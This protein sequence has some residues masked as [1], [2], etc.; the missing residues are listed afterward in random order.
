MEQTS[1]FELIKNDVLIAFLFGLL[2][3][4][5]LAIAK[6]K[7]FF[8]LPEPLDPGKIPLIFID[9]VIPF[10]LYIG[11]A[12]T[13]PFIIEKILV[14][15]T[16]NGNRSEID[17]SHWINFLTI[18]FISLALL[19]YCVKYRKDIFH[20]IWKH[21]L[22][23]SSYGFDF[24]IGLISW[25]LAF[26]L[27]IF[28]SHFLD[29]II[30]FIFR[31]PQLPQQA[32]IKYL[33]EAT[34]H[35]FNFLLALITILIFAPF[36]EELIFR[37]FLQTWIKKF[38]GRRLAIIV[39]SIGFAAFHFSIS[40]GLANITIL[41]TLFTLSCLLGFLYERQRSLLATMTLHA[42]FNGMSIF[43]LFFMSGI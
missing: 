18:F 21:P 14:A 11:L 4:I 41:G 40:Q 33:H 17:F 9:V 28:V 16:F 35:P 27:V 25:F 22:S 29:L 34:E 26:P 3:L 5:A 36:T 1:S 13:L 10:A 15:L 38:M 20:Y 24:F 2:F 23:T 19:I 8:R 39:T 31:Q 12:F 37:G 7:S 43:N 30:Y 6:K 42:I 32:A